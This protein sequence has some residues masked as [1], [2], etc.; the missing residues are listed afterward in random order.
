MDRIE[1]RKIDGL[2]DHCGMAFPTLNDCVEINDQRICQDC[3]DLT[4]GDNCSGCKRPLKMFVWNWLEGD[5]DQR[6]C[7]ECY[8][9]LRMMNESPDDI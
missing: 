1:D 6:F 3:Y 4:K 5:N 9:L 7:H 8:D 2:C